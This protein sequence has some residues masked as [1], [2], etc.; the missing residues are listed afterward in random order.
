MQNVN[1]NELVDSICVTQNLT[2]L[3]TVVAKELLHYDIL[4]ALSSA[5][6]LAS[7][8][9]QGGT[10]L[11]LCYRLR[12]YSED[13]DFAGGTD[14]NQEKFLYIKDI[15]ENYIHNKYG[16]EVTVKDP[17]HHTLETSD[18]SKVHVAKWQISIVTHPE[19]TNIPQQKIRIEIANIPAYTRKLMPIISNYEFLPDGYEDTFV[20]VE[21]LEEILADKIIAYAARP[22]IKNRD[23]WDLQW[24][25][26]QNI[27]VN[28]ELV[29][30]KIHDYGI[31]DFNKLLA[32]KI[33]MLKSAV[34]SRDFTNELS[35]FLDLETRSKTLDK[36]GF[37]EYV[38][39][40]VTRL[41]H[42]SL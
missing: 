2:T 37:D 41:L 1:F 34:M 26:Q 38:I 29:K 40:T 17:K 19:Q 35:R 42:T 13:L 18:Q 23:I 33:S 32:Y 5:G 11:R 12:R 24:L 14:F 15:L 8:T 20:Y 30:H 36:P 28:T 3:R 31:S 22:Y 39:E 7:L 10:A 25:N 4:Q 9:F 16:M 6:V 27:T 21:S